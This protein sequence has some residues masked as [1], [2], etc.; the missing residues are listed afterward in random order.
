[1]AASESNVGVRGAGPMA[2]A[3]SIAGMVVGGLLSVAFLAD[4]TLGVPFGGRQWMMDIGFIIS[5]GLLIYLS[6]NAF[7]DVK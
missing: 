3:M 2:K 7:R 4:L 1:M 5:A 6:W